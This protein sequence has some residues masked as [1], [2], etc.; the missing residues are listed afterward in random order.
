L[1]EQC[2]RVR[3]DSPEPFD[4]HLPPT[5]DTADALFSNTENVDPVPLRCL[6]QLRSWP[7][8]A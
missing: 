8:T 4:S 5:K 1:R 3:Q 7:G 6:L 2:G